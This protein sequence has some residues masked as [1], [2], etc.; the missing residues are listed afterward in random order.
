MIGAAA[1]ARFAVDS[2]A[3]GTRMRANKALLCAPESCD[4]HRLKA[5]FTRLYKCC[6]NHV[7]RGGPILT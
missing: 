3:R 4:I 6:A 7:N 2:L 5:A 1:T